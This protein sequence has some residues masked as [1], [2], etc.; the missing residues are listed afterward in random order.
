MLGMSPIQISL[1]GK[2]KRVGEG[3]PGIACRAVGSGTTE[4]GVGITHCQK[5]GQGT[6][7]I[8]LQS[9]GIATAIAAFMMVVCSL[10]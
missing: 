6:D 4:A 9:L 8:L 3:G 5:P 10:G 7:L 1:V 2:E